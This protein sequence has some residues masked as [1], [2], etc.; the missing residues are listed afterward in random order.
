LQVS[1]RLFDA[2]FEQFGVDPRNHLT[3]LNFGVEVRA[4]FLD[5]P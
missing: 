5:L 2:Q 1:L 4:N 3:L